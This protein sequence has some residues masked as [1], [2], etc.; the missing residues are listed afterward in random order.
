VK[1]SSRPDKS[2]GLIK[3][4]R[5]NIISHCRELRPIYLVY[6]TQVSS[7]YIII[8]DLDKKKV[9]IKAE[10]ISFL[11]GRHNF[12]ILC[13]PN[14]NV[15]FIQTLQICTCP[16]RNFRIFWN[17]EI[18]FSIFIKFRVPL[19]HWAWNPKRWRTS[20]PVVV[21]PWSLQKNGKASHLNVIQKYS[22]CP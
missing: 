12:V 8:H 10:F 16:C 11:E 20:Q 17:P 1:G 15:L 6:M 14:H 13:S 18:S 2:C 3:L 19:R 9:E 21:Y 5:L 22:L 7:K 4:A